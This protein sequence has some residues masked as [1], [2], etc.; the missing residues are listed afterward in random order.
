MVLMH[1]SEIQ[2]QFEKHNNQVDQLA[3]LASIDLQCEHKGRLLLA[4]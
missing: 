2:R 4:R 1:I 3:Q